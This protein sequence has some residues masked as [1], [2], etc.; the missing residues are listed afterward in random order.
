MKVLLFG[1]DCAIGERWTR[2]AL[3]GELPTAQRLLRSGTRAENCLSP[4]PTLTTTNWTTL[5]TGAWPGTHGI[6]DFNIHKPGQHLN[7]CP[8]AFD[9]S[10]CQAEYIWNA[11][12]RAGKR[13][14]LVN[15]PSS[16]PSPLVNGVQVG[17][18]GCEVTDWRIGLPAEERQVSLA[19]EQFFST[20]GEPLSEPVQWGSESPAEFEFPFS[21]H[22]AR[23]PIDDALILR[24]EVLEDDGPCLRVTGA[25]H[26]ATLRP[27][28]WSE[29][30]ACELNAGGRPRVAVF[31]LKLLDLDPSRRLL[32]LFVTDVCSIDGLEYPEHIAGDVATLDGLPLASMGFDPF[33]LGWIDLETMVELHEMSTT[34]IAEVSVR[35]LRE[36]PWDLFYVHMHAVDWFYHLASVPLNPTLNRDESRRET[37][38]AAELRIYKAMDSAIGRILETVEEPRVTVV[39]S[40]HGA[41]SFTKLAPTAQILCD[42]GLLSFEPGGADAYDEGYT[43][44]VVK[45]DWSQT[46]A[47]PQR[48][49][50][51]YINLE[52]RDPA[53]IVPE[54]EYSQVQEAIIDALL[55]Y[56]DPDTGLCPYSMVLRKQDAR[57]L[58]LHGDRIGDVVYAVREEFSDEH[59]QILGTGQS[60][61]GFGSLGCTL[62][63]EGPGVKR[64]VS[65]DR[66]VWLT[67]VVPTICHIARLPIPVTAEGSVIYQLLERPDDLIEDLARARDQVDRLT[68][69]MQR[70]QALTHQPPLAPP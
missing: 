18:A 38:E 35:L 16:W 51:I 70:R 7:D 26:T 12:A 17:G 9:S 58:G 30:F 61:S 15:Y 32:R 66:T 69:M 65:I 57:V 40:D 10:D 43:A 63:M 19:A 2:F 56:R 5:A 29:T 24:A 8:Q 6:T 64:G 36:N 60:S 47:I 1:L 3:D 49:C 31:R 28:T 39:V 22:D 11:A 42:A 46:R 13:S 33:T 52:G 34:W 55:S 59:G 41:S 20:E 27:G 4:L 23:W 68:T 25:G 45:V 67:D 21:F 14:V 54:A 62:V 50:W 37:Y 48:S 53:G 44:P